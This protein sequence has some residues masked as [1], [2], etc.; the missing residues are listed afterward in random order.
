MKFKPVRSR[1]RVAASPAPIGMPDE[2]MAQ[3]SNALRMA[4]VGL[5]KLHP[6]ARNVRRYNKRQLTALKASIERFGVVRPILVGRDDSIIAGVA[7]WMA[8]KDLGYTSI[9]VVYADTLTAE[10][11]G[12]LVKYSIDGSIRWLK[13]FNAP[14]E[15]FEFKL[16][17]WDCASTLSEDA[18][19]S[20]GSVW[21]VANGEFYLLD[22]ERSR[23]F[24]PAGV[25]DPRT[26]PVWLPYAVSGKCKR[27]VLSRRSSH[28][29]TRDRLNVLA[30]LL[31]AAPNDYARGA[32]QLIQVIRPMLHHANPFVPELRAGIC[33]S[34]CVGLL[35]GQLS[36]D[37]I[38]VPEAHLIQQTS[39]HGS[40]AVSR[41]FVRHVSQPPQSQIERVLTHALFRTAE[42]WKEVS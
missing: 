40:E 39:G 19:W 10:E 3:L 35:V 41:H 11:M 20:V 17:S 18:D 12:H 28:S 16:V 24:V 31:S 4:H 22:V 30:S 21:G 32:A 2:E 27:L 36:L 8:A 37:S 13:F 33:T 34:H 5:E 9:P 38:G 1:A 7:I 23:L 26:V 14:P 42:R 15:V 25:L 29:L 6:P